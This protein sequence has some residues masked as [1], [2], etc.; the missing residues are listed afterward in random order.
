M[1]QDNSI[2]LGS[3]GEIAGVYIAPPPP[4]PM[5]VHAAD[6]GSRSVCPS[7]APARMRTTTPH[8]QL[9]PRIETMEFAPLRTR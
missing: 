5:A 6:A 3:A 8:S 2:E 9:D 4:R 1:S 7:P